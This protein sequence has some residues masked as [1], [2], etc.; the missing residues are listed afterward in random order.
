MSVTNGNIVLVG[1]MGAGKTTLGRALARR[2]GMTF[3]D[4][5][6]YIEQHTNQTIAQIFATQ[7][8]E[9]FRATEQAALDEVL[10]LKDTVIAV[11]GGTPC[12]GNNMEHMNQHAT[13]IYLNAPTHTLIKHIRMGTSVRPLIAGKTDEQLAEYIADTMKHREPFYQKARYTLNIDTITTEQQISHYVEMLRK[14]T[15][16]QDKQDSLESPAPSK[17]Q[18]T[19]IKVGGKIVEEAGSLERLLSD[20]AH[21][22]GHKLLV[23]GGGRSATNIATQLGIETKMVDGRRITDEAM[24]RVVTMVYGGLVNKNIVAKLQAQGLNALGLTGADMN[25]IQSH[26]RPAQPT[27]YGFVGDVDSVDADRLAALIKTGITPVMAPLT[28]DKQ[29]NML[30]TNADTIAGEVAKAMTR[31]FDVTLVFCFEKPGVLRDEHDDSSVIPHITATDFKQLVTD[32]T[33]SGGMIPKLQNA[34]SAVDAGV[35]QVVITQ[36]TALGQGQGTKITK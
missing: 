8:E 20:F 25:V 19:I 5:D 21:I 4:L 32:G 33:I 22:D 28:H 14:I 10:K 17:P 7:G 1:F 16:R 34:L 35:S 2:C 12:F 11:G 13:T 9:A 3:C 24:L 36:A 6:D 15:D 18:L 23:H 27:D 31:H 30:N 29:G 26:R